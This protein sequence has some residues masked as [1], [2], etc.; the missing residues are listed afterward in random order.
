MAPS[1]RC[2][3]SCAARLR[4]SPYGGC[5]SSCR[6]TAGSIWKERG[7][8]STAPSRLWLRPTTRGAW[9]AAQTALFVARRGFLPGEDRPWVEQVGHELDGLRLRAL[10]TYAEAALRLG[11]TELATAERASRELVGLAPYRDS[12]YRLL[13]NALAARGNYAEALRTYD[14]LR[15]RLRDDLGADPSPDSQDL[16]ASMLAVRSN[17]PN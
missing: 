12:A 4:R 2:C 3:P 9:A 7:R 11:D 6:Q 1:P 16:H 15:H 13:M 10:E 17:E 8:R 14:Q 5:A